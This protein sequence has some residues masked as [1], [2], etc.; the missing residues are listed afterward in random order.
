MMWTFLERLARWILANSPSKDAPEKIERHRQKDP[1]SGIEE[2]AVKYD[3]R[4]REFIWPGGK[5]SK[6]ERVAMPRYYKDRRAIMVMLLYTRMTRQ[7]GPMPKANEGPV[8][9]LAKRIMDTTTL[10]PY[11]A[12]I[13][14]QGLVSNLEFDIIV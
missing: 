4:R 5:R 1:P 6:V 8:V 3:D 13:I 11:A 12:S 10:E 7:M 2:G 14:A 9:E